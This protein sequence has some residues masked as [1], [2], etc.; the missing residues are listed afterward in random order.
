MAEDLHLR[1]QEEGTAQQFNLHDCSSLGAGGVQYTPVM[2]DY[3]EESDAYEDVI[4]TAVLNAVDSGDRILFRIDQLHFFSN[5]AR[6]RSRRKRGARLFLEYRPAGMDSVDDKVRSE[7]AWMRWSFQDEPL[8]GPLQGQL[9]TVVITWRRRFWWESL[10]ETGLSLWSAGASYGTSGASIA[11]HFAGTG[12]DNSVFASLGL[13]EAGT[14]PAPAKIEIRHDTAGGSPPDI[15][16]VF[17]SQNINSEID[18]T[19]ANSFQHVLQSYNAARGSDATSNDVS[20]SLNASGDIDEIEYVSGSTEFTVGETITGA[21]SG[22]TGVVT[23]YTLDS[24]SW[25]GGDAAGTLYMKDTSGTFQNPEDL[26]GSSGGANMATTASTLTGSGGGWVAFTWSGTDEAE[27][28][29]W[30]LDTTYLNRANGNDFR[31]LGAFFNLPAGSSTY[32]VKFKI[33]ITVTP[34]FETE[35]VALNNSHELQELNAEP[36]RLPP[37][38]IP[39]DVKQLTL[40]MVAKHED[41]GSH[42]LDLDFI[43]VSPLDGWRKLSSPAKHLDSGNTLIDDQIT[44]YD[45]Y[46]EDASGPD[47]VGNFVAVGDRPLLIDPNVN[48]VLYFLARNSTGTYKIDHVMRIKVIIRARS[49][50]PYIYDPTSIP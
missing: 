7:I 24:G 15:G 36:I 27:L 30:T 3:D 4:E 41:A 37:Q 23:H 31:V 6:K 49:L 26:D 9:L 22:A 44:P 11:N 25:A 5:V 32:Q 47:N 17:I 48:Q 45:P 21:T 12:N 1:L 13:D 2:P 10:N 40:T 19:P 28:A 50:A 16:A 39:S 20:D 35:W 38:D 8:S 43:Q 42:Q 18:T 34:I 14:L 33:K 29:D 46:V